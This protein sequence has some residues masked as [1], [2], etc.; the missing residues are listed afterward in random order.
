M[1][2][3]HEV[4]QATS[5]ASCAPA[6]VYLVGAG[7]GD[8]G[9]ITLWGVDCLRRA[10]VVLYDYLANPA[11]LDHAP[12]TAERVCL[13]HHRTGRT[14]S[15]EEV[16]A[17][18]VEA[19]CAGRVVVRLKGGD[20]TVFART[21]DEVA[22]LRAAG[23]PY[24]IIPGITA[25]LAAGNTGGCGVALVTGHQRPGKGGPPLD[26][27]ALADFPGAVVFYMGVTSAP[28]WSR[29]M[30][31]RGLP[32]ET[33]VA[34]VRHCTRQDQE[35]LHYTLAEI[36][37]AAQRAEIRPPAVVIVENEA[38]R[39]CFD[40]TPA[41]QRGVLLVA[42]GTRDDRTITAAR[43]LAATVA[44]RLAGVPV[45]LSFL[46]FLYP[47]IPEGLARLAH[48]GVR[49]AA[50]LPLF[51]ARGTHVDRDL[52][53]AVQQATGSIPSLAIDV[54]D[55]AGAWPELAGLAAER[56]RRAIDRCGAPPADTALLLVAHGS[57]R[58]A[59]LEEVRRFTRSLAAKLGIA[60]A[61]TAFAAMGQPRLDGVPQIIEALPAGYV[62][63]YPH[64]LFPGQMVDTMHQM[65]DTWRHTLPGR[66]WCIVE[67]MDSVSE[68]AGAIAHQLRA[69]SPLPDACNI[70]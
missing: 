7:P 25:G 36:G 9:L 35:V 27:G 63:V 13:G 58:E 56:T 3:S 39:R 29:A 47:A 12:A 45:E 69:G 48:R 34:V 23:V 55:H 38:A 62:A 43:T 20:P 31:D 24:Q 53:A 10:E 18:M 54:A 30:L 42:H 6:T 57:R 66:R 1:G 8:P 64:F 15:Q 19:A 17:R 60:H 65:A 59:A 46:E 2:P 32:P 16:N 4:K 26:Y 28:A 70:R 49:Q 52:P 51:L 11:L 40:S 14:M 68:L 33:P 5:A 41:A 61:H 67:P 22:A 50:V 44:E 21:A 37:H